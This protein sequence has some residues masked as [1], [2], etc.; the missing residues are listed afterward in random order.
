MNPYPDEPTQL[1][2]YKAQVRSR[3]AQKGI[4][5]PNEDSDRWFARVGHTSSYTPF[6]DACAQHLAELEQ[7][8]GIEHPAPPQPPP[9]PPAAGP[10]KPLEGYIRAAG[11]VWH[12]DSGPRAIR[13][14]S[15]FPAVRV[16]RDN[17]SL[18]LRNLDAMVGYWHG[19]RIFWNLTGAPW[20]QYGLEVDVRWPNYDALLTGCLREFAARGLRVAIT[21]GD[22]FRLPT[23]EATYR[24]I[25]QLCASVNEQTVG[26]CSVINEPGMCAPQGDGPE[27]WP[28]YDKLLNALKAVYPWNHHGTGCQGGDPEAIENSG[29]PSG[30]RLG[31]KPPATMACVQGTRFPVRNALERAFDMGYSVRPAVGVPVLEEEP[32]G[33]NGL[34]TGPG[35]VYQP[36]NDR[37]ALFAY[38]TLKLITGQA[39]IS[40]NS[41][42]LA[43][44]NPLESVWGFK[45]IPTLWALMGIPE[46]VGTFRVGNLHQHP[47]TASGVYRC[48][49]SWSDDKGLAFAVASGGSNWRVTSRWTAQARVYRSD[50]LHLDVTVNAGG[51]IFGEGGDPVPTVITLVRL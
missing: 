11:S 1:N 16:Y 42:G 23:P 48:D 27:A 20:D 22:L 39:L 29:A 37:D 17:R 51:V 8:L 12:D 43:E 4:P 18:F 41:C 5:Y 9:Q 50:G 30:V 26:W 31:S 44:Q 10:T 15:Y 49:G 6:E 46:D 38:Y 45:E 40:L 34:L 28:Y 25:G 33:N 3:Y 13:L 47:I 7:E 35:S 24:R 32:A 19:A 21:N 2:A 36:M 14:C